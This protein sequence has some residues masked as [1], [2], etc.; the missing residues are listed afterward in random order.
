M[1]SRLLRRRPLMN[2]CRATESLRIGPKILKT[3]TTLYDL[4][5]DLNTKFFGPQWEDVTYSG[6]ESMGEDGHFTLATRKVDQMFESGRIRFKKPYSINK[7]LS[8]P[9]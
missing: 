4:I 2:A 7:C 1:I 3:T 8:E 6:K 5:D 9:E